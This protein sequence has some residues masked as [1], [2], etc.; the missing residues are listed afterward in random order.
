MSSDVEFEEQAPE[1]QRPAEDTYRAEMEESPAGNL[2]KEVPAEVVEELPQENVKVSETVQ[3]TSEQ[4]TSNPADTYVVALPSTTLENFTKALTDF[5]EVFK[6][7]NENI[8]RV[9]TLSEEAV[10]FYTP[11]GMYQKRLE[12]QGSDF[13]QGIVDSNGKLYNMDSVKF[14]VGQGEIKGEVALLKVS[15]MLGL[16]DVINV[17][18]PHSGVWVTIKPPTERDLIDFYNTVFRE[19]IMLG[20]MT[21]GLTFSNF[22][23]H[24]NNRLFEFI[25]RHIHSLN[26]GDL[27]KDELG[28]YM[29][30]HDFPILA[31]GLARAMYPNG[32]DFQRACINNVRECTHIAKDT[33]LLEKLIW[34]DNSAL[35]QT[36]RNI[37][38]ENRPNKLTLE[39]YR[40]F[41]AE[42]SRLA[43]SSYTSKNGIV[44]KFKIPTFN[45]YTTDGLAWV[46]AISG[47]VE[48]A[49]ISDEGNEER[50]EELLNQYVKASIL[51]QFNHF[52]D[53]I[54]IEDEVVVDRATI[55]GMLEIFSSDD[56]IREELLRAV[57]DYKAKTTLAIIGIEEYSCPA[58]GEPQNPVERSL[59]RF[60]KVIPL[61][62]VNLFFLMLTSRISKILERNI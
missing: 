19:K 50:R 6:E 57:I 32:F 1:E 15:K 58:C 8:N 23:V 49:M 60:T 61:D 26:Y 59:P 4:T 53:Q 20:R 21:S 29:V 30:I 35:S 18:L 51:R 44:F 11:G 40:T 5:A 2:N 56:E 24:M 55:N 54:E 34:V 33:L 14:K 36:Q 62:S 25:Q 52:I 42:H 17:M 41:V 7:T 28:N 48:A 13:Q 22:S 10:E 38:T 47:I 12:E 27:P 46:N 3:L 43:P 16:G 45:E 39:S 37:L 31:H 9:R